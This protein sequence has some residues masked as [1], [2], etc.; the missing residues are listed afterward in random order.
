MPAEEDA[1]KAKEEFSKEESQVKSDMDEARNIEQDAAKHEQKSARETKEAAAETKDAE[2]RGNSQELEDAEKEQQDAE[3]ELKKTEE[4]IDQAEKDIEEEIKI[5]ENQEQIVEGL[6]E[7]AKQLLQ[8]SLGKLQEEYNRLKMIRDSENAQVTR[9]DYQKLE[10]ILEEIREGAELLDTSTKMI[11]EL[12]GEIAETEKEQLNVE[13]LTSR[14]PEELEFMENEV[15]ELLQDYTQLQDSQHAKF[16][17]KEG[18][19]VK[20]LEQHGSKEAQEEQ[21]VDQELELEIREAEN[22][23]KED[24]ELFQLVD[25]GIT[26][27]GELYN[28]LEDEK[29]IWQFAIGSNPPLR[30]IKKTINLLQDTLNQDE[31]I[32]EKTSRKTPKIEKN[33]PRGPSIKGAGGKAA[34]ASTS[35][36]KIALLAGLVITIIGFTTLI[37]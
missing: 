1:K 21:K 33:L 16:A 14:L 26:H 10:S 37:L 6:E 34:R 2:S 31:N 5:E 17:Q 12:I 22:I 9:K 8:D 28:L 3:E 29:S 36:I 35:I 13:K 27:L 30:E 19:E 20:K 23:I 25:T 18:Q 24:K 15:S 4:E 11:N 32:L 7:E